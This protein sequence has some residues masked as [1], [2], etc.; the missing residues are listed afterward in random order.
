MP[1]MIDHESNGRPPWPG[2]DDWAYPDSPPT[3]PPAGGPPQFP[4]VPPTGYPVAPGPS[5]VPR[6]SNH[7][8]WIVVAVFVGVLGLLAEIVT[9]QN[10]RSLSVPRRARELRRPGAPATQCRDPGGGS[11]RQS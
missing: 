9:F 11:G 6:S 10:G 3:A 4:P 7:S 2:P 1:A 5:P 8:A